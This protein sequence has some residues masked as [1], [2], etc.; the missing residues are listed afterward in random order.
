MEGTAMFKGILSFILQVSLAAGILHYPLFVYAADISFTLAAYSKEELANVREWE[1]STAGRK[2]STENVDQVKDFLS[3]A[4][5]KAMKDPGTFGAA[6]LWFEVA[7]Y[8]PYELSK[9]M[10]EATKKYAPNSKLDTKEALVN[11]GEVAGIPFPQPKT[12]AEMAWNFD[13]NTRGDTHFVQTEGEVVDCKTRLERHAGML[14]WDTFWMSRTDVPPVPKIPDDKN[15]RGI[16]RSFFQRHIAPVDFVDTTMLEVR[17][18][19]LTRE[20]DLWVYTAMFRRIRRYATSQRTDTIDG[21]DMI[22]D[23]QDGW[24]TSPTW[25]NYKYIGRADLLVGR[26]VDNTKVQRIAGQG[27]WNGV[28]RERVNNFAVEVSSK[29]KDYIYSKQIWYLDPETWQMNFKVMYNR[30]GQLWKMYEMFYNEYPT[31]LGQKAAYMSCEHTIDF[32]RNHGSTS[33][34]TIK[35]LSLEIPLDQY[36]TKSLKE[37]SY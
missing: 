4:V 26:H 14:R 1:K 9:G 30:Q 32:I 5:Y 15:P 21:T 37:K 24:Y 2:I 23:D 18:K 36:Q 25:N 17:Y 29:D 3:E 19:D 22:Y 35:G 28:Q 8:R 10:I 7:P 12:G 20:E 34:Y 6:S 31:V 27:F 33:K 11:F 13:S 16:F